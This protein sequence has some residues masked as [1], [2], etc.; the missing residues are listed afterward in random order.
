MKTQKRKFEIQTKLSSPIKITFDGLAMIV[1]EA[2]LINLNIGE[3]VEW[4]NDMG[5][6][7]AVRIS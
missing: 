7:S 4:S 6:H 1:G 2:K 3:R 5:L